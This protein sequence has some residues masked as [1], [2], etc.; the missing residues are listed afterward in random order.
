MTGS[1]Y[2]ISVAVFPNLHRL[3]FLSFLASVGFG[4]SDDP[5]AVRRVE[6]V[7]G[8]DVNVLEGSVDPRAEA[9]AAEGPLNLRAFGTLALEE[10]VKL[11]VVFVAVQNRAIRLMVT[12]VD[13][14]HVGA[15]PQRAVEDAPE[16]AAFRAVVA[17]VSPQSG[18]VGSR[19]G[20]GRNVGAALELDGRAVLPS[21]DVYLR[22]EA[23]GFGQAP[24]PA[25]S[26]AAVVQHARVDRLAHDRPLLEARVEGPVR[27]DVDGHGEID[28]GHAAEDHDQLAEAD[29]GAYLLVLLWDQAVLALVPAGHG[30]SFT[31]R[32]A[33]THWMDDA[34]DSAR[35]AMAQASSSTPGFDGLPRGAGGVQSII[36]AGARFL[37]GLAHVK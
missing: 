3:N 32:C 9:I 16:R 13:L 26:P 28:Y 34:L 31:W 11:H 2:D 5:L 27:G 18:V 7:I 15:V 25:G 4:E 14:R 36:G 21:G 33:G 22:T 19:T 30:S 23:G 17:V 35:A 6:I 20:D 1:H 24:L 37:W 29:A 12:L 10:P 8:S